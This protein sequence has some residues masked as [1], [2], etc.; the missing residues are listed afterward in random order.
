M[1]A[2]LF[3]CNGIL[4][5][6][7]HSLRV[8]LLF[9]LNYASF[10][11]S[12]L[13]LLQTVWLCE[14]L[15]D[16]GARTVYVYTHETVTIYHHE[17]RQYSFLLKRV[18]LDPGGDWTRDLSISSHPPCHLSYRASFIWAKF[19]FEHNSIFVAPDGTCTLA[20]QIVHDQWRGGSGS[21][22]FCSSASVQV[23]PPSALTSTRQIWFPP[24]ENA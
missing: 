7:G 13:N 23:L 17:T 1:A 6:Q 15:Y 5:I 9:T 20:V 11:I 24:P 22:C 19:T 10:L 16:N 8:I 12:F 14:L 18:S 21:D 2:M 3:P 4:L